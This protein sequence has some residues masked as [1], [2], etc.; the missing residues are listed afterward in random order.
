MLKNNETCKVI[1]T[2]IKLKM[3]DT[4]VRILTKVKHAPELKR[5]MISLGSLESNGCKF[6]ATSGVLNITKGPMVVMKGKRF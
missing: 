2:G 6:K 5:N 4:V 3:F 1:R